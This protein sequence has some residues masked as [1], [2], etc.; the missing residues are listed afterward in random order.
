[1]K[2]TIVLLSN[3]MVSAEPV[4]SGRSKVV[5]PV[6]HHTPQQV[7]VALRGAGGGEGGRVLESSAEVMEVSVFGL[8]NNSVTF[9]CEE[10][11]PQS[12]VVTTAGAS[13]SSSSSTDN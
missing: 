5:V 6:E 11:R 1:M 12:G 10:N 2:K 13:S 3:Q 9:I 4:D 8:P 7:L